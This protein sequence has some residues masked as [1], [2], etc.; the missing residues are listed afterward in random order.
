MYNMDKVL[1]AEKEVT[2]ELRRLCNLDVYPAVELAH[3]RREH[4]ALAPER[5]QVGR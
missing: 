4:G 2:L 1:R 3:L 5:R